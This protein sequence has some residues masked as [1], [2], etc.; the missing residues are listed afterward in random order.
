MISGRAIN[1]QGLGLDAR[2]KAMLQVFFERRRRTSYQFVNQQADIIVADIDALG[3]RDALVVARQ[4]QTA[5]PSILFSIDTSEYKTSGDQVVLRKPFTV[6]QLVSAFDI[7]DLQ[8][9]VGRQRLTTLSALSGRR[10]RSGD[11]GREADAAVEL[12]A[13]RAHFSAAK[14][15]SGK[16]DYVKLNTL[17][18]RALEEDIDEEGQ[19]GLEYDTR[20]YLQGALGKAQRKA[21]EKNYNILIEFGS[22]TI[23]IDVKRSL[24]Q[25]GM[26]SFQ[27]RE[28]ASFPLNMEKVNIRVL[29]RRQVRV[30]PASGRTIVPL[31]TLIWKAALFASRG[32][33]PEGTNLDVPVSLKHWPNFT[34]LLLSPGALRM[35]ALWTQHSFSIS[36]LIKTLKLP[37]TD[38]LS[39]YSAVHAIDLI[40]IGGDEVKAV[41]SPPKTSRVK[42]LLGSI[43]KKLHT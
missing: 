9:R 20:R 38:V 35:A 3:V 30:D 10:R 4:D 25:M 17:L 23:S 5:K 26:G 16:D 27:L 19:E 36:Q 15:L 40:H 34:R 12:E 21:R 7:M 24:A 43:L 13:P 6:K 1:I 32:R 14:S 11:T 33:A 18:S 22:G 31:D 41:V 29:P 39:F 2:F 37:N 42:G 8:V 28:L